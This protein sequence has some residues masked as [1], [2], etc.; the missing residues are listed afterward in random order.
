MKYTVYATRSKTDGKKVLVYEGYTVPSVEKIRAILL[1]RSTEFDET[2]K[3]SST[4]ED[5][6]PTPLGKQCKCK[7]YPALSMD[8]TTGLL[9]YSCTCGLAGK[10]GKTIS[11]AHKSWIERID[12]ALSEG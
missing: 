3:I 6:D 4:Q 9:K 8:P 5:V 7:L 12:R 2:T 11:E 10:E 1:Q